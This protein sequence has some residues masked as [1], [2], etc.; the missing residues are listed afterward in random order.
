MEQEVLNPALYETLVKLYD[1]VSVVN[2]GQKGSF[3]Q[4][5]SDG[6]YIATKAHDCEQYKLNCPVCG[7]TRQRLYVSHWAFRDLKFKSHQVVTTALMFCQNERCTMIDVRR[8]ISKELDWSRTSVIP[9]VKHN[10]RMSVA[11]MPLPEGSVPI[12]SPE[13]PKE[14]KD[15][16][17]G[18]GFDLDELYTSWDVHAVEVLKEQPYHG[19]KII[20][21]VTWNSKRVF[22]Q[23]R[24]CFDPTKDQQRQGITKYYNVPGIS[25]SMYIY[26]RD[27]AIGQ[28]IVVMVE[29]VTDVHK[30]GQGAIAFFGKTPSTHQLQVI[31]NVFS[32]ATGVILLDSDADEEVKKFSEKYKTGLFQGGLYPVYL[33]EKDPGSYTREQIWDIIISE[34]AG[35]ANGNATVQTG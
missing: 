28:K 34:I 1:K 14:A 33:K 8:A 18:R 5:Y 4:E 19:P 9:V 10:K 16:L 23:A 2:P 31:A 7:D 26:N 20:Y 24:L 35:E 22:W 12:N 30:V 3:E 29:G 32:P 6:K 25:K 17:L 21:P 27:Q 13:A 15:Y 11:D